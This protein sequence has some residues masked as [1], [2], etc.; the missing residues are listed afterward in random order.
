MKDYKISEIGKRLSKLRHSKKMT[1]ETLAEIL[2]VSTK[3]ISHVERGCASLSLGNLVEI[4]K[5][6]DCSLDYLVLGNSNNAVLKYLPDTIISI[7]NSGNIADINMLTRYLEIYAE[8]Y[9]QK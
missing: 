2:D 5:I 3:H 4:C 7:L 1:Q 9:E 8:L 6:F